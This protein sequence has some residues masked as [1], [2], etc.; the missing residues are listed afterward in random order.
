[1]RHGITYRAITAEVHRAQVETAG[2]VREGPV[3]AWLT[4]DEIAGVATS[5]LVGKCL[6]LTAEGKIS[7]IRRGRGRPP[8]G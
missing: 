2:E 1:V 5:S 7:P 6:A 8:K 3:C 4:R